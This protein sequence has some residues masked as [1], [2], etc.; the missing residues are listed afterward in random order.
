MKARPPGTRATTVAACVANGLSILRGL[1]VVPIVA[2]TLSA[3]D[4][5]AAVPLGL[6]AL[7][8]GTDVLD[9]WVARRWNARSD[10]G[11]VLD[12]LADKF[13]T[14]GTALALA[15]RGRIPVWL[16]GILVARDLAILVL[17]LVLGRRS[18][19]IP[20]ADVLGKAAFAVVVVT[21]G[22]AL[23]GA[24]GVVAV[25]QWIALAGG[26]ASGVSY[27]VRFGRGMRQ[28]RETQRAPIA[29]LG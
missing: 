14:G 24:S 17:G 5:P 10:A 29:Q 4:G 7:A 11:R 9:G 12:P 25:F 19:R 20:E 8:W 28:G 21:L 23:L 2:G 6:L 27:G 3:E 1:L 13:V 26:V 22:A 16:A 18:G 15:A